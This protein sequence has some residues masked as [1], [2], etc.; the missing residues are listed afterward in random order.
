MFLP[1]LN[2]ALSRNSTFFNT[3]FWADVFEIIQKKYKSQW[4]IDSSQSIPVTDFETKNAE[5]LP[6]VT[7][8]NE[9]GGVNINTRDT[10]SIWASNI[11]IIF[12]HQDMLGT[13]HSIFAIKLVPK[14][15]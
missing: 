4:V 8:K 5:I 6:F 1:S 3:I 12:R 11:D 7:A 10:C 2:Q 14:N 15:F 9:T 13:L